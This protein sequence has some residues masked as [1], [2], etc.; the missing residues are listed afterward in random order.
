MGVA[1]SSVSQTFTILQSKGIAGHIV[2]DAPFHRA[3]AHVAGLFLSHVNTIL[4]THI[5][6][7]V[8]K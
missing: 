6:R 2:D 3:Y 5:A 7:F 4:L 1:Q 8:S